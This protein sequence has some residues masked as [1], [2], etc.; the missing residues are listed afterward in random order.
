MIDWNP[1]ALYRY[2][3]MHNSSTMDKDSVINSIKNLAKSILPVG[4]SVTLFGSRARGSHRYDSDWDLLILLNRDN[5]SISQKE[6]FAYP[7]VELGWRI[8]EEINPIVHSSKEWNE[9]RFMPLYRNIQT[10]G[11]RLWD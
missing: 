5:M 3:W 7:F 9:R 6:D 11:I 4:S 8:D 1:Q 2:K 10:D